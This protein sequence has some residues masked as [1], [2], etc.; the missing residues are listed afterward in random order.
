MDLEPKKKLIIDIENEM[1]TKH[2]EVDSFYRKK[3]T[4]ACENI[5]FLA[6]YKDIAEM[7]AI[8]KTMPYYRLF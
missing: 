5:R 7:V 2:P 1:F 4:D 6:N 3:C 8:K